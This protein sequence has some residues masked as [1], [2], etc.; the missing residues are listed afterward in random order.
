MEYDIEI[1]KQLVNELIDLWSECRSRCDRID[2]IV[3]KLQED[4][5]LR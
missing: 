2:E 3:K 1:G 4:Y 5:N